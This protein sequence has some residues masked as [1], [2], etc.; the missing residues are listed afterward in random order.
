MRALKIDSTSLF[1]LEKQPRCHGYH[2][3]LLEAC[4]NRPET[5]VPCCAGKR[6][7]DVCKGDDRE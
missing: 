7:E 5:S 1:A 4:R 6:D 2:S 3:L